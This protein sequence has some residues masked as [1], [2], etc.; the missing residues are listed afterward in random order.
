[1]KTRRVL[2]LLLAVLFVSLCG[3]VFAYM[4]SRTGEHTY[5]LQPATVSCTVQESFDGDQ[6][7][8]IQIQNTGTIDAYLRVRLVSYWKNADG[9]IIGKASVIPPFG[10]ATDWIAG[11][12][13]T[14]YYKSPVAP[15]GTTPNL[16]SS[17]MTLA[18][19]DEDGNR[20]VIEV[21]AEAIQSLPQST[22]STSWN[23]SVDSATGNITS[24]TSP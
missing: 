23:V 24:A 9:Q 7:T 16:L 3:T 11:P 8:S 15:D 4:F 6:K 12:N 1:M 10:L 5:Q 14:Y 19:V 22:V 18:E 20:Q 21:F 17:A 2:V 13:N